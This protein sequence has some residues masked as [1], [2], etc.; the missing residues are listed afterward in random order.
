MTYRDF[1]VRRDGMTGESRF[2]AAILARGDEP[3]II[4][5]HDGSHLMG[6]MGL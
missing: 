4:D 2:Y 1:V 6:V 5:D 3:T